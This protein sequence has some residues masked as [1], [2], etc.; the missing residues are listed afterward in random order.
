MWWGFKHRAKILSELYQREVWIVQEF[1][2]ELQGIYSI[3]RNA[4][5]R[6]VTVYIRV[7]E[8][9]YETRKYNQKFLFMRIFL[10]MPCSCNCFAWWMKRFPFISFIEPWLTYKQRWMR[11]WSAVTKSTC[12]LF[13]GCICVRI[14]TILSS[15]IES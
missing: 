14:S 8:T 3:I 6:D 9:N 1:K 10:R 5:W 4:S 13:S 11:P 7:I 15:A 12:F 2:Y